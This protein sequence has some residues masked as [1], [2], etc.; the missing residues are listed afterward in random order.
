MVKFLFTTTLAKAIDIRNIITP[1][2]VHQHELVQ[3]E[4]PNGNSR[5]K[6]RGD[7]DHYIASTYGGATINFDL[8]RSCK[9]LE[10]TDLVFVTLRHIG[11]LTVFT[12]KP[13][14]N[15]READ[16]VSLFL[17]QNSIELESNFNKFK[18]FRKD[19][20]ENAWKFMTHFDKHSKFD[21]ISQY[22]LT[23]STDATYA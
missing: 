2:F 1:N 7:F 13:L 6:S 10:L 22:A 19:F 4:T 12:V 18:F 5:S 14:R 8:H 17:K 21:F 16:Q 20:T 3:V 23:E 11:L 9:Q 15:D